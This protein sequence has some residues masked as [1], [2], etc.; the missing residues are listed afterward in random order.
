[1]DTIKY[2]RIFELDPDDDFVAK[3]ASAIKELKTVFGK[4]TVSD[5]VATA[6]D[7]CGVFQTAP[8]FSSSLLLQIEGV[9]RKHSASFER[10]GHELE[11]GI[12]GMAALVEIVE[13]NAPIRTGWAVA[14][15]FAVALWSA[16]S[17]LPPSQTPKLDEFRLAVIET[18]RSRIL[19]TGYE[20]RN[21]T[22]VILPGEIGDESVAQAAFGKATAKAIESLQLNAAHD[23]E[24]IE[25][26]WWVLSDY[27]DVMDLPHSQLSPVTLAISVGLEVGALLRVLPTQSHRNLVLRNIPIGE[28]VTLAEMIAALGVDREKLAKS[29]EVEELV[30]E[31]P[32][33]FPLLFSIQTGVPVESGM[34]DGPRPLREWALRALLERTVL[35]VQYEKKRTL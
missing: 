3:R 1:M 22:P 32:R 23:R 35:G 7:L 28:S 24:E 18:A 27:S 11:I 8:E 34:Q 10:E 17:F 12:C 13:S 26:L 20:S 2:V 14:D 31:A 9:I 15:V 25:L 5:I 29:F 4:G 6:S 21:R 19:R 33:V 30:E 16:L